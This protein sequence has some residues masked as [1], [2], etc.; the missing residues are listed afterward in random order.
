MLRANKARSLLTMLGVIIGVMGVTLTVEM[1]EG[2]RSY[3]SEA[4]ESLGANVIFVFYDPGRRER[5]ETIFIEGLEMEDVEA[6]R[7][8][9]SLVRDVSAEMP[10][11][12]RTVAY[13]DLEM[14]DVSVSGIE[15]AYF[16][17]RGFE[18]DDGRLINDTDVEGWTKNA[19]LGSEV[20]EKLFPHGDAVGSDVIILGQ[21]LRV[22]G[23]LKS[24]GSIFGETE[25]KQVF[26]PIT[27]AQKRWLGSDV[28][29]MIWARP[30]GMHDTNAAMD[31]IWQT[32]MR[33]HDNRPVFRVGSQEA[34]TKQFGN[35][36]TVLGIVFA[37]V[38]GLALLV[39]GIGIMNIM[40]V[41]VTERTREIGL[42]M[43]VGAKRFTV[44]FQ[45]LVEAG[46]L[47]LVGGLIGMAL[48]WGLGEAVEWATKADFAE[49]VPD[50][51][52][53]FPI[54]AAIGAAVFSAS[55]GVVFGIY[56]AWRA[57]RLDPIDA[58]RHE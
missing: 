55:V 54:W 35:L 19:V 6:V 51:T 30:T 26:I 42:R 21:S 39:G 29:G 3:M 14:E 7:N 32:L 2:F 20:A 17:M 1:V 45:F 43:A 57:A 8:E 56:P 11:G 33:H 37:G 24:K 5:G 36:I 27:A 28:V 46:T 16:G 41:S 18:V 31:Q 49:K 15:E 23:T 48:G 58:L 9:C 34:M 10:L 38:A 25:D 22:I 40:L 12:S 13:Y 4:F 47:S 44:L 50:T 52:M 53:V